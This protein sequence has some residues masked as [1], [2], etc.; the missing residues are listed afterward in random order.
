VKF[1]FTEEKQNLESIITFVDPNPQYNKYDIMLEE[2]RQDTVKEQY[3]R[4][5]GTKIS[6][7]LKVRNNTKY[8][9]YLKCF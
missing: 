4:G 1:K 2:R 3:K 6:S 7:F 9:G 8:V 5:T